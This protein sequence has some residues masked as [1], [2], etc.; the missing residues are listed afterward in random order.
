MLRISRI[1]MLIASLV[2]LVIAYVN[3]PQIFVIMYFGSSVIAAS[4]GVVSFGSVWSKKLSENGAFW[5]MLSGFVVCG[6]VRI[7]SAIYPGKW[8]ILLE[9]F[10]LGLV[11]SVIGAIIGTKLRPAG[12]AEKEERALLF[13][14]PDGELEGKEIKKTRRTGYYYLVFAIAVFL[15]FWFM[16]AVPYLN[17]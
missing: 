15:F 8:P 11:A 2:I 7:I 1:G 3:P 17:A 12:K 10:V 4:W 5:S 14:I 16:W 6:L 13:R 9:P